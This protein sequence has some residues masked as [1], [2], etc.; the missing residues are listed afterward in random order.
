MPSKTG[1]IL[2]VEAVTTTLSLKWPLKNSY[3]MRQASVGAA[4]PE[5]RAH[6]LIIILL[7]SFY[8]FY[9]DF[10]SEIDVTGV[11]PNNFLTPIIRA[12]MDS[13]AIFDGILRR[14]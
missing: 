3:T 14:R 1:G 6:F 9:F 8:Y 2:R 13:V 4:L 5:T 7:S 10:F 12:L 11:E